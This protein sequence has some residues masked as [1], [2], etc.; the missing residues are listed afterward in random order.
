[1]SDD[2][3][4]VEDLNRRYKRDTESKAK[5]RVFN[6]IVNRY[7]R[8]D[9]EFK[10]SDR[11]IWTGAVYTLPEMFSYIIFFALFLGLAH[12]SFERYG[13]ART[14]VFFILL[15]TWRVQMGVKQLAKLNDKL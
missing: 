5:D 3:P 2:E 9:R 10:F 15:L 4:R 1:M 11:F 13:E 6:W 7:T 8:N 12:F 14:I